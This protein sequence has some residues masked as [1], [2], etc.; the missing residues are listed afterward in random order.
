MA[1][2]RFWPP[3]NPADTYPPA[4]PGAL[5]QTNPSLPLRAC[6][7]HLLGCDIQSPQEDRF[8]GRVA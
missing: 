7:V 2:L 5:I 4:N 1:N 3:A 8:P 6:R